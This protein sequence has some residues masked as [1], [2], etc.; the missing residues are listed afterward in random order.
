MTTITRGLVLAF[1]VAALSLWSSRLAAEPGRTDAA[2]PAEPDKLTLS[3]WGAPGETRFNLTLAVTGRI[4]VIKQSLPITT[5]GQL[6]EARAAVEIAP[7]D[8]LEIIQSAAVIEDFS[9]GCGE[10]GHGTNALLDVWSAGQHVQRRCEG[11][12]RW[13]QGKAMESLLTKLNA[14]LPA[15]FRVY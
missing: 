7:A 8:A 2:G 14:H 3:T 5:S 6:T 4:E 13:P 10:V 12:S 11:A 1:F 9:L 15:S